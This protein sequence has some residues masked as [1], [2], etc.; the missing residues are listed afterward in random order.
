MWGIRGRCEGSE[1]GRRLRGVLGRPRGA[2]RCGERPRQA[3]GRAGRRRYMGVI[4]VCEAWGGLGGD[5]ETALR[6]V[7]VWGGMRERL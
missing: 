1:G 5:W 2:S 6:A 7:G 4:G 3:L